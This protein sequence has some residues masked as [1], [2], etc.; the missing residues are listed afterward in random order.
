MRQ[1]SLDFL[2][3][4][5]ETHSPSGFEQPAQKVVRAELEK[6]ADAV[7]TD[8]HGNVMGILHPDAAFRVML[9]GHCDEIGLMVTHI[10]DQGYLFFAAI[11]G[12]DPAITSG[13]RVVVHGEKGPVPGVI[14]RKPIHLMEQEERGKPDKLSKQWIDIGAKDKKDAQ[15]VVAVGNPVTIEA[16]FQRLRGNLAA[17][18]G[19][20]DKAGAF[21]VVEALR[22]LKD[23]GLPEEFGVYAVSTVQE[24]LGLRGGITSA[25][26]I[27]PAAGI[28]VDVG[29]ASDYPDADKKLVGDVKLGKGPI[30]HRGANINPVL[31]ALLEKTA[32]ARKIPCQMQAEPRATGTDANVIQISRAGVA[33]ALVSVPN[34]Y[35]HSPV[36]LVSLDDL[37]NTARLIA[38]T[39]KAMKPGM[40]FI[41]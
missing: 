27:E 1:E 41:P 36:E 8:V 13:Q 37:A 25:Y 20:D 16:H 3:A 9:A 2:V 12:V 19:F 39:V 14:G 33:A 31:G 17:A 29:F 34:R 32:K 5:L 38:E 40:S 11:G 21:V 35:M 28:A 26:A 6:C 4:L 10:D 15:K 30:L 23:A 7:R 22:L 24:E 18:K